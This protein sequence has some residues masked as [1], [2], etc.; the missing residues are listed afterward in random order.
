MIRSGSSN[1]NAAKA[2]NQ[3]GAK[4]LVV[5]TTLGIFVDGSVEKLKSSGEIVCRSEK[6]C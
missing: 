5:I 1:I 4:E 3:A 2:Y 6:Y